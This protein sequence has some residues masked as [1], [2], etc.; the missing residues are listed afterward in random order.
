MERDTERAAPHTRLAPS[1][2][3]PRA[4][5]ERRAVFTWIAAVAAALVLSMF[6]QTLGTNALRPLSIVRFD[7]PN[8]ANTPLATAPSPSPTALGDP[9]LQ[10][11]SIAMVS[12]TDGWAIDNNAPT[13]SS[14]L[15]YT[16]NDWR[17]YQ[18]PTTSLS[19]RP[20]LIALTMLSPNDGWAVGNDIMRYHNGVWAED[21]EGSALLKADP[22]V[23]LS[24]IAMASPDDGW[25][26]GGQSTQTAT[27]PFILR[28]HQ[29]HW[30]TTTIPA[31]MKELAN[32]NGTP[33]IYLRSIALADP[34]NGWII[35]EQIPPN[36]P[37]T[38]FTLRLHAGQ[39]SLVQ[40]AIVG[41]FLGIATP[42][43]DEAW[44]V[45]STL[46]GLGLIAH[47]QNDVWSLVPSPTPNVLH[48]ITMFGPSSGWIV[49][50]GALALR[51]DGAQWRVA[52]P[53]I[54]GV[55]LTMISMPS[56]LDGWAAGW[57][58]GNIGGGS[59][60][61]HCQAGRWSVYHTHLT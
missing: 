22:T 4:P 24:S 55:A 60:M 20:T 26:I 47:F 17:L 42:S 11:T 51:Y 9:Q 25:A 31:L 52:S 32:P 33:S 39:W 2:A 29:G 59:V 61:L 56:P 12:T 28:Y 40:T 23:M 3:E 48:A 13:S 18:F 44:A 58:N 57:V 5:G 1:P 30:T 8:A 45:G 34:N 35:A 38:S 7:N 6:A 15:R 50:E 54:H 37:A 14:L 19:Y 41:Q 21:P 53:V 10:L 36:G 49:G 46:D 27:V 43:P 16:G